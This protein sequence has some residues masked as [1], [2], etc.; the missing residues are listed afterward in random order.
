MAPLPYVSF[1]Q[2]SVFSGTL[3]VMMR[4][5]T[6]QGGCAGYWKH[7][8]GLECAS[9]S[10]CSSSPSPLGGLSEPREPPETVR[11]LQQLFGPVQ[12]RPQCLRQP[13][14]CNNGIL[15]KE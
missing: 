4:G 3:T 12:Q 9:A 11:A 14:D 5:L 15:W 13:L 2:F 1:W 10:G 8:L 7:A 6:N